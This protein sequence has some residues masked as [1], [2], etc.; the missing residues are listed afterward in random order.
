MSEIVN[1][2][3]ERFFLGIKLQNNDKLVQ[4]IITTNPNNSVLCLTAQGYASHL[5]ISEIR[6]TS[7]QGKGQRAIK[8]KNQDYCVQ[9]LVVPTDLDT[10]L[11]M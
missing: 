11:V 8:V 10:Y 2:K 4:T 6:A 7:R 5:L 3:R 1:W 9:L